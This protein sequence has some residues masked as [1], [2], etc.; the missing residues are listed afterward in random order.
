[1]IKTAK[2]VVLWLMCLFLVY[3]FLKAGMQKFSNASGWARAFHVW[4]YPV[5]F[6]VLVGI[7]EISAALLLLYKRLAA[8]GALLIVA[9]MLGGMA[10]HIMVQHRPGQITSEVFPLLLATII[11]IARRRLLPLPRRKQFFSSAAD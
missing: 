10:T 8:L 2:E 1:V 3:V 4:G 9:I 7:V 5:W 11:F 6:R